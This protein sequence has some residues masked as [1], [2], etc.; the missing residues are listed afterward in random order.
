MPSPRTLPDLKRLGSVRILPHV[1]PPS[2]KNF[3]TLR[4]LQQDAPRASPRALKDA[5]ARQRDSPRQLK[6]DTF[7]GGPSLRL[8]PAPRGRLRLTP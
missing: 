7:G 4:V 6:Q 2:K 8:V 3:S 5:P 1:Y